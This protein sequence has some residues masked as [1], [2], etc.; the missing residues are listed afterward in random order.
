MIDMPRREEYLTKSRQVKCSPIIIS[1]NNNKNI[2][3]DRDGAESSHK[4]SVGIL[5]FKLIPPR[6]DVFLSFYGTISS[7]ILL[8]SGTSRNYDR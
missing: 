2:L 5:L 6:L 7:K 8:T 4:L 1:N 3:P